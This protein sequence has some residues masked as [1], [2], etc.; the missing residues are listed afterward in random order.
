MF[1]SIHQECFV[2]TEAVD[3]LVASGAAV[4]RTDAVNIGRVLAEEF[5]LFEHVTRLVGVFF[6][7]WPSFFFG[8]PSSLTFLPSSFP[9]FFGLPSFLLSFLL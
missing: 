5:H 7:L 1:I 2:G 3:Y 9:S 6:L 8:L 4:D